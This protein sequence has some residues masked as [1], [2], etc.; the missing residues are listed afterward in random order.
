[1][2][3]GHL[4]ERGCFGEHHIVAGGPEGGDCHN[5][6]TGV[7]RTGEPV[8]VDVFP[9]HLATGYHGDCTRMVVHGDITDEVRKMHATVAEAKAAGIAATKAGVTGEDV[10]KAVIAVIQAKGYEL[11]FPPEGAPET[12]CS[13]PHGTGHGLG[14]DLKEP[15]LLDF[16]G[17]EL[18]VGDAVTV[19]PG[20]YSFAVG[21]MRLED[22]VIVGEGGCENLNELHEGLE[23]A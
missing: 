6:G 18:V 8:I 15:P 13:M 5:G 20:L 7:L 9:K 17:P 21:G 11:G 1:M 4:A 19:E 2:I 12:F 14:L 16:K 23:W 22:L 10:H 3:T